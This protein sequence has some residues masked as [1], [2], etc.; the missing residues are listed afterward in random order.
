MDRAWSQTN[1]VLCYSVNE[2]LLFCTVFV[3]QYGRS[4]PDPTAALL[5][6]ISTQNNYDSGCH[7]C[8]LTCQHGHLV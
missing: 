4:R 5:M 8:V 2:I 1:I 6:L 3:V 7:Q